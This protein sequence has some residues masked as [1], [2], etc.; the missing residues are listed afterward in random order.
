VDLGDEGL[1]ARFLAAG[2]T[3][4]PLPLGEV[5]ADFLGTVLSYLSSSAFVA[6]VN[7]RRPDQRR[8]RLAIGVALI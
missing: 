6:S 1:V 5:P 8:D 7:P 3:G 4:L 2:F